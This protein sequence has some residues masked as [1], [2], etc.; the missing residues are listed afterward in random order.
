LATNL[1]ADGKGGYLITLL[2]KPATN[3]RLNITERGVDWA[4]R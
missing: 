2:S 1:I 3:L 4:R